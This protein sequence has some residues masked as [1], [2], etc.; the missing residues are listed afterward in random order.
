[1]TDPS[2]RIAELI[3]QGR[4]IEA[5]KLLRETTGIGLKEAKEAVE[6]LSG[7]TTGSA[8]ARPEPMPRPGSVSEEV[9]NL[10]HQGNKIEAIK[11]LREQTGMGLKEAKQRVD[12]VTGSRGSG[13]L[14][15]VAALLLIVGILALAINGL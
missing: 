8:Q 10:A 4:K 9:Q 1:M 14:S 5:I 11:L 6:Q 13:C 3:Q 15:A 7:E 12:A 2:E